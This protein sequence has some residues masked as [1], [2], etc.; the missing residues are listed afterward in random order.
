LAPQCGI[1]MDKHNRFLEPER[2]AGIT[3][4]AIKQLTFW[5][6]GGFV[7]YSLV[8]NYQLF[9]SSA[10]EATPP[11]AVASSGGSRADSPPAAAPVEKLRPLG[12]SAPIVINTLTLRAGSDG[13][14]YVAA[15]V[16]GIPMTMAFDTGAAVVSLNETDAIKAG[17]AGNLKY[18][19]PLWTA[20]GRNFGAPV[21]LR[22]IRIGQ[23]V[24]QDVRA[25][26]VPHL[27]YS[28][29]GQTFLNRLHSYE[30]QGGVLTLTWQ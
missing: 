3:G 30:M 27:Q 23:L 17:V 16:N 21:M 14:A 13:Y 12:Q 26:V 6:V 28:L 11:S 8:V 9:R 15:S 4:W 25:V 10:P 22:E 19:M 20:N 18:T 2:G 1:A 29:L 24:I 5:S 7:V